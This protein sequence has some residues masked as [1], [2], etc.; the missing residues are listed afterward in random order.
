MRYLLFIAWRP[1]YYYCY[2][3][4]SCIPVRL[5][6]YTNWSCLGS[7]L[8]FLTGAYLVDV[9]VDFGIDLSNNELKYSSDSAAIVLVFKAGAF[10]Y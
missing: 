6:P 4:A 10:R 5:K 3:A 8:I 9:F 2:S 1:P 7:Y